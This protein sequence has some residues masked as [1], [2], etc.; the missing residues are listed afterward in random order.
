MV[1][2]HLVG[3]LFIL[4]GGA[5]RTYGASSNNIIWVV[6]Y[7]KEEYHKSNPH[8]H[9]YLLTPTLSTLNSN[10]SGM[11]FNKSGMTFNNRS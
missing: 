3:T 10:K 11:T 7:L 6:F 2:N 8:I 5:Q 1:M 4:V 9:I